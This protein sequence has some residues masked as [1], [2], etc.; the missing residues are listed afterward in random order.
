[1]IESGRE[2]EELIVAA[3]HQA[4]DRG[5]PDW[6]HM[7][8]GVLKNRM[9]QLSKQAFDEHRFGAA[10][11]RDLLADYPA[12][13][14]VNGFT[15]EF[16]KEESTP[17]APLEGARVRADLWRAVMDY[18]SGRRYA[19]DPELGRV[20]EPTS[21]SDLILPTIART[22]FEEWRKQFAEEHADDE[23]V[24]TWLATGSGSEDLPRVRQGEWNGF[25]KRAVVARLE[26]WFAQVHVTPPGLL[27]EHTTRLDRRGDNV[28]GL[29]RIVMACVAVMTEEELREI[30]LPP[31]AV[32]RARSRL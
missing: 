29:R 32:L 3:F 14:R 27:E 25:L 9:L 23:D 5:R 10:S 26:A 28:E 22:D 31:S 13:V 1:M 21:E 4:R 2:V 17:E 30:R 8:L 15:V 18:S 11:F 6:R 19:W 20:R 24:Q 7:T 16:L 12:L